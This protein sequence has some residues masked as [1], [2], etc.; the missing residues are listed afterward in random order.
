MAGSKPLPTGD[1][2]KTPRALPGLHYLIYMSAVVSVLSTVQQVVP[3]FSSLVVLCWLNSNCR[4]YP[5]LISP[6]C[7]NPLLNPRDV[8]HILPWIVSRRV[9]H[10]TFHS[11]D[12]RAGRSTPVEH[13]GSVTRRRAD[14]RPWNMQCNMPTD[15]P[16]Q[17]VCYTP[18]IEQWIGAVWAPSARRER[19][20]CSARLR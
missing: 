9:I 1:A 14:T 15:D 7:T 13:A 8:T 4:C 20:Q 3:W 17:N 12:R 6:H 16:R 19:R 18:W 2:P 10:C 11:V 5:T